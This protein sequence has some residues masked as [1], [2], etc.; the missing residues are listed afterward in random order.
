MK[1]GQTVS[2]QEVQLADKRFLNA[3]KQNRRDNPVLAAVIPPVF[4]AKEVA[5]NIGILPHTA[6]FDPAKTGSGVK[7]RPKKNK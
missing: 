6:F 7:S 4:K 3:V 1:Q 2:K 5:E